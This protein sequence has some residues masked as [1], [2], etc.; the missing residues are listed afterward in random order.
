M[1]EEAEDVTIDPR[2]AA[3]EEV[4]DATNDPTGARRCNSS[5]Q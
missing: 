5:T 2:D 3:G 4:E 1:E